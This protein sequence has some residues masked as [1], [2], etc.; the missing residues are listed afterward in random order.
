MKK[1]LLMFVVVA[2]LLSGCGTTEEVKAEETAAI[3]ETPEVVAT[4]AVFDLEAY[5]EAAS[6]LK[7]M[8]AE[9]EPWT[10]GVVGYNLR[11]AENARNISGSVNYEAMH[12]AANDYSKEHGVDW[13]LMAER[14]DNIKK[15]YLDFMDIETGDNPRAQSIFENMKDVCESY[16]ECYEFAVSPSANGE[17][18]I[19]EAL[20]RYLT[21]M[22][23]LDLYLSD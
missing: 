16:L 5:K 7:N 18:T 6:E 21:A 12:K 19:K 10:A 17:A 2:F 20:Q 9:A 22:D 8:I 4:D 14:A 3:A 11:Y 13:D 23:K 15:A 1:F